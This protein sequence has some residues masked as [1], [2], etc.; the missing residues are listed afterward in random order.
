MPT[1]RRW[2]GCMLV[3]AAA[4]AGLS[5]CVVIIPFGLP[6]FSMKWREEVVQ[7]PEAFLVRSK[8]LLVDVSGP[9]LSEDGA[10]LLGEDL[11]TP[12]RLQGI[13]AL[14]RK[15]RRIRA[16]LLRVSSPGGGAVASD[17]MYDEL[18]RFKEE[19]GVPVYAWAMDVCAS[20][21]YYVSCAADQI[22][23]HPGAIV[24]SVGVISVFPSL[25]G[26]LRW[27]QVN[28]QVIKSGEAKD[29][30]AFWRNLT[31]EERE[32]F[33]GIVNELHSRFVA[34]VRAG[35]EGR[36]RADLDMLADGRVFHAGDALA[37]GLIDDTMQ[38]PDA[39][40]RIKDDLQLRDAWVVTYNRGFGTRENIYAGLVGNPTPA[41]RR[42]WLS[43]GGLSGVAEGTLPAGLARLFQNLSSPTFQYLWLPGH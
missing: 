13:L 19:T 14:A 35:R 1:I 24:G 42:Q 5:A 7:E 27:A 15:D 40:K 36:L 41:Q 32:H 8:I 26:T 2:I 20:G 16:V 11:N 6:P 25:Q 37:A 9:I 17:I 31:D 23:A 21:A 22:W 12:E 33:Q 34:T 38:L 43:G 28:M 39:I 3:L 29:S 10:D 4:A 18:R 30:G